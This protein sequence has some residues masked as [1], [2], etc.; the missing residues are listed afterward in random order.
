MTT[1][2]FPRPVE[3]HKLRTKDDTVLGCLILLG[4]LAAVVIAG[5]VL[6]A[7]GAFAIGMLLR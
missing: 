2:G 6:C 3:T 4:T 5:G 1:N 7:G